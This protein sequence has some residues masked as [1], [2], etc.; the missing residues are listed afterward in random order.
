MIFNLGEIQLSLEVWSFEILLLFQ[1]EISE[2]LLGG[3]S[4]RIFQVPFF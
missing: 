1:S 3:E 2:I 4:F